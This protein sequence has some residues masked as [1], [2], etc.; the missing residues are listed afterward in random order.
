MNLFTKILVMKKALGGLTGKPLHSIIFSR[1]IPVKY[2]VSAET[3]LH[4]I[5]HL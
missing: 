5:S 1:N 4:K 2:G 3:S